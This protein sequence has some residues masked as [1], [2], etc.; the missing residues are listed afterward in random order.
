MAEIP[1][2]AGPQDNPSDNPPAGADA[3]PAEAAPGTTASPAA[4]EPTTGEPAGATTAEEGAPAG[5]GDPAAEAREVLQR[6]FPTKEA[7]IQAIT[8]AA[9]KYHDQEEALEDFYAGAASELGRQGADVGRARREAEDTAGVSEGDGQPPVSTDEELAS[10]MYENPAQFV[11]VMRNI[12]MATQADTAREVARQE[13]G[14]H[15]QQTQ[16]N[17]ALERRFY[18]DNP[19]LVGHEKHVRAAGL[20]LANDP[21]MDFFS[22]DPAQRGTLIGEQARELIHGDSEGPP[23]AQAPPVSPATQTPRAPKAPQAP[24]S[25]EERAV[26]EWSKHVAEREAIL[27]KRLGLPTP[28]SGGS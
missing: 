20:L 1:G 3:E 7:R 2:Q 27:H 12:V 19:D 26:S 11:Q 22:L 28:S 24:Q 10:L 9:S 17:E 6:R 25:L 18:E 15:R 21:E 5:A 13:Y 23:S 4:A 16:A 14:E 8:E